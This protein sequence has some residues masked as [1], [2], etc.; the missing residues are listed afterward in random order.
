MSKI[1]EKLIMSSKEQI[2][3]GFTASFC[4]AIQPDVPHPS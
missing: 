3:L 1:K 4:K 2:K